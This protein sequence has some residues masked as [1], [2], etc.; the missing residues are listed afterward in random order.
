MPPPLLLSKIFIP[1]GTDIDKIL[2]ISSDCRL[3]SRGK[4][5]DTGLDLTVAGISVS[6]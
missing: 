3:R 4:P 1:P 2:Y 5:P 6:T